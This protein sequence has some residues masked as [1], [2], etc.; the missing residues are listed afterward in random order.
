VNSAARA[1]ICFSFVAEC[2]NKLR[3][4]PPT[5]PSLVQQRLQQT[6]HLQTKRR[7]KNTAKRYHKQMLV[8]M[9]NYP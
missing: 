6:A 8:E 2:A 1:G 3:Y 5:I 9:A 4:E 7:R